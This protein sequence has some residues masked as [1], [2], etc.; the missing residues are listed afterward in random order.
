MIRT[1][2]R[3]DAAHQRL[4]A[5]L[6]PIS[7]ELFSQRPSEDEWSVAQIVHHLCLVEA[8]VIQE[9]EKE[10][11]N[12]PRR[13]RFVRRLVPTSIVASRLIRVKAPKAMNPL[14]PPN[15]EESI[16]SYYATRKKLKDLCA[17]HGKDR[18][19][20]TIF[21][22]PF[23]GEID[24]RATISFVGYHEIRHYKQVREVLRKLADS[25]C[26]GHVSLQN[27]ER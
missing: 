22:H 8:R 9:I 4:L 27:R 7:P 20:Q 13:I 17:T 1:L 19:K 10:L 25:A 14:N 2:K 23:L 5:T 15:K 24:G 18:L 3:L 11:A 26:S 21:K 16:S 6:A 12:P